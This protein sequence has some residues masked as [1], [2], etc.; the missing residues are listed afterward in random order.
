VA[1]RN[2]DG[3]L[4]GYRGVVRDVSERKQMEE[5]QRLAAIGHLAAGVAHE[6][7]NILAAMRL[8]AEVTLARGGSADKLI[9]TVLAGAEL[10]GNICRKLSRFARPAV[11][12]RE[13]I[14]IEAPIEAALAMAAQELE[15][16]EIKVQ[17][18]YQHGDTQVYGDA[19]QLEQVFL[20]LTINA[21]DAMPQGGLLTIET[22]YVPLGAQHEVV[23]TFTDTGTGISPEDLPHVFEPF[24]TTKR[25]EA[26]NQIS[27]T[28]L[29]LS[30]SHRIVSAHGGLMTARS[31]VG[32]GATFELRL[33]AYEGPLEDEEEPLLEEMD[34]QIG[35]PPAP[36][37]GQSY[38]ILVVEDVATVRDAMAILLTQAGHHVVTAGT[39]DEALS[40][41]RSSPF[42]LVI[43]DLI[44][45]GGGG[46]EVLAAARFMI[47]PAPVVIMTGMTDDAVI[48][49]VMALGA[50]KCVRKPFSIDEVLEAVR[51]VCAPRR[52]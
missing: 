45:K 50:K 20:N 23:V 36:G 5:A 35:E 41:M 2:Q 34:E 13:P 25:G 11:P 38:R 39:T 31:Q 51:E 26:E 33:V 15:N 28:G 12:K 4:I 30:V 10:G 43:A 6:F 7:N 40:A 37:D 49:E 14:S 16:A 8:I 46:R 24:F 29:G 18:N 3:V 1:V 47:D 9:Q 48:D 19:S 42:D 22:E 52:V 21:C 17:R 27:G 44:L 32:V